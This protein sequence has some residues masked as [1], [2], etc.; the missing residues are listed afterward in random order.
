MSF[1]NKVD[2]APSD[3][4]DIYLYHDEYLPSQAINIIRATNISHHSNTTQICYGKYHWP[5]LY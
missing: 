2:V 5:R 3:E 4:S 1:K